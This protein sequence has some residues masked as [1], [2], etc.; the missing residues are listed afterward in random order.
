MGCARHDATRLPVWF[1]FEVFREW[2]D[3]ALDDTSGRKSEA[4]TNGVGIPTT[5]SELDAG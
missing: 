3:H 4:S 5:Y 2:I 1:G